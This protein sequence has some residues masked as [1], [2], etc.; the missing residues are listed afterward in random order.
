MLIVD[1]LLKGLFVDVPVK[2]TKEVLKEI[3]RQ[4]DAELG[5]YYSPEGVQNELR[6]LQ[7]S[8]ETGEISREEYDKREEE[9]LDVL[10]SLRSL[11]EETQKG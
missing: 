8:L 6:K 5:N 9:L 7:V 10:E 3:Q 11:N 4:V 1:D 2:I